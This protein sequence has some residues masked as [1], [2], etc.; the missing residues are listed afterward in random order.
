MLI[1]TDMH[2]D[3]AIRR[4]DPP[5]AREELVRRWS[6]LA[7]DPESP[8]HFELNQFGELIVTPK[9]TSGHQRVASAIARILSSQLG[10]EGV[11]DVSILTDRGVRAPDV[12][13]MP[14]ERWA[15]CKGQSPLEVVPDVCVEVLSPSNTREEIEMKVGAYLRGGAREVYVV[16]LKGEIEIFGPKG[17]RDSSA[18]GIVLALPA[19]LF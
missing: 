13:W 2:A 1:E 16:G 4:A 17:K 7:A 15:A 19:E 10:G 14:S 11:T 9:P 6:A 12:V 18:L 8:D 3:P 5:V